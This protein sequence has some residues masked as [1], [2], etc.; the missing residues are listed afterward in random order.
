MLAGLVELGLRLADWGYS[1]S[2][3]L[4]AE[5]E[6][7]RALVE[8]P[9]FGWRFFPPSAAR[10][11]LPLSLSAAKP[12]GS[13]RIFVL[14]ESAAMGD[15]EP[16]YGFA[17]QLERLLRA[18][19]PERTIEVVNVAMTAINSH[20]I[21]E[22]ARDCAPLAGDAWVIYAGNN[23]V[24][25]PFGA[26]TVF[27]GQVPS[28]TSVRA[29]L[30]WRRSRLGQLVERCL[31]KPET[32]S[33]Q[34]MEM[35]LS[36]QVG[37]ED[38]RLAAVYARFG[39]NL[40]DTIAAGQKAG[41]KVVI[42]TA[43]VNLAD[44]P[45]F[46]SQH[47]RGLPPSDRAQWEKAFERGCRAEAE[48]RTA[49]ALAAY[50]EAAHLDSEYAE[51]LFRRAR[52]EAVQGQAE[53][54]QADFRLARDRDT[55]RFRADSR[56]NE[57]A[58]QTAAASGAKLIDAEREFADRR[59]PAGEA[60][61]Y[62]HV[63]L[64]F[65]GNFRLSSRVASALEEALFSPTPAASIG[66]AASAS[67]GRASSPGSW[68]R[69][70]DLASRLAFTDFDR[71]RVLEEMRSRL[72]QPPFKTQLDFQKR[73]DGLRQELAA[74][75]TP[76]TDLPPVYRDALA[77]SPED[78]VLHANFARLLEA[79][80]DA[81][82][83]TEQWREVARLCPQE[84]DAWFHLGDLEYG[85]ARY[86]EA[87]RCFQKAAE[88]RAGCAEA[89]NGLGLVLAAEGKGSDAI[90]MFESVLRADARFSPAHVNL[91]RVLASRGDTLGAMEQYRAA[92]RL[93]PDNA[94]ARIN[95]ARLLAEHEQPEL[96]IP[97]FVEALRLKPEDP[98]AHF[99]LA[100]ALV[101]LNRRAEALP[102]YAAAARRRPDFAEARYNFGVELARAGRIAEA[103]AEFAAVVQLQPESADTR[104][105]YGI[106]LAKTHR[107]TE[108][109]QEFREV[110]KLKPNYPSAQD[111]LDRALGLER[112]SQAK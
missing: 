36:H 59:D 90:R 86:T 15:P 38:P 93:D 72:Q 43:P 71:R 108:A 101:A 18:R 63:H 23:E 24:V 57:I 85:A 8:N 81:P 60:L 21:R 109:I 111:A 76:L 19:H 45:P 2:F 107:Y 31:K 12:A 100:N 94:A 79:V 6:G 39:A 84:P 82:G 17:R 32:A 49:D 92:L 55:L 69:E 11:P 27:G 53:A 67:A 22:I 37:A 1:A 44:C 34:G 104:Y 16:A 99:N 87:A 20:V 25:G 41:A 80:D 47:R 89:K 88:C 51:L 75:P 66:A 50:Q 91:A 46:A 35:F 52:C 7:R 40:A 42:T 48:N 95:L 33:W 3:F 73:D 77:L 98:V 54:A 65:R 110:L 83:A 58:R 10:S 78:W 5:Q 30:A 13:C 70:E 61:F 102:H 56:L 103:L 105:N 96:A 64:N 112:K 28:L 74:P 26:G 62:D 29:T 9:K 106:A 4:P 14:G 68:L 97:L